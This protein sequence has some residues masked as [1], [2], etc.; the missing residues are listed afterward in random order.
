MK[1]H[2]L[3]ICLLIP[4]LLLGHTKLKGYV[5]DEEGGIAY[6]TVYINGS[7]YG[8]TTDTLGYF[9]IQ[10]STF[11]CQLILSHLSYQTQSL[12]IVSP[13]AE[14]LNIKLHP[15]KIELTELNIEDKNLRSENLALFKELFLGN[16]YWGVNAILENED[17]L[18]FSYNYY[19]K[20]IRISADT[21]VHLHPDYQDKILRWAADSSSL[22]VK[23]K[24]SFTASA[25]EALIVDLPLLGYK[26]HI[27]LLSFQVYYRFNQ[28][29][30]FLGYYYFKPYEM[31]SKRKQKQYLKK[32]QEA[33]YNS[34]QHFCRS[35]WSNTLAPNGYVLVEKVPR[36][37]LK[38][39]TKEQSL[40]KQSSRAEDKTPYT[41]HFL[42]ENL[43][44]YALS[45]Y[46][47]C[48]IGQKD[49]EYTIMYYPRSDGSPRALDK[50]QKRA[51]SRQSKIR[52]LSDTCIIH[53][54]GIIPHN[55]ILFGGSMAHKQVGALLPDDYQLP[56]AK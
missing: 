33:Y 48:I 6:A 40:L 44:M 21:T 22:W 34:S 10:L 14:M 50:P 30:S 51:I 7:T 13:T 9:E 2:L 1:K 5:T 38:E 8:T 3:A 16:D 56:L 17:V 19:P 43:P 46:E 20:K 49:K 27:N 54:N 12:L 18:T 37:T 29:T 31:P 39:E 52:F 11:P 53:Q 36:D 41:L 35:L 45:T 28:M 24:E 23:E 42:E 26:I 32:R 15:K 25:S 55:M 47:K 4:A